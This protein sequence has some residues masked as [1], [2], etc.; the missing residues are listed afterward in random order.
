[1]RETLAETIR[2]VYQQASEL[3]YE[4]NDIYE[5]AEPWAQESPANKDRLAAG[6]TLGMLRE[7]S[8]PQCLQGDSHLV[9]WSEKKER[10]RPDRRDNLVRCLEACASYL[11]RLP[12]SDVAT[13]RAQILEGVDLLNEV[14]FP[15]MFPRG[16][17]RARVGRARA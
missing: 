2:W 3:E 8:V 9:S 12:G 6:F 15:P 1:M 11:Y 16:S 17:H 4:M 13:L 5:R 10:C 14:Y 7:P